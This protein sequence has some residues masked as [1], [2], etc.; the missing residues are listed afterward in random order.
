MPTSRLHRRAFALI[1]GLAL[2][3]A[4]CLPASAAAAPAA[5]APHAQHDPQT[6][7]ETSCVTVNAGWRYAFATNGCA[8][9]MTV[10]VAYADQDTAA[11]RVLEPG[12][13]ATFPGYGPGE[14]RPPRVEAC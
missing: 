14:Y 5:S 10:R 2:A 6:Q 9:P 3:A 12:Q 8:Y 11:C 7:H 1:G 4:P 13:V